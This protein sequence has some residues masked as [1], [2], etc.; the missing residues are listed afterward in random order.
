MYISYDIFISYWW[1]PTNYISLC[2]WLERRQTWIKENQT[3]YKYRTK[4]MLRNWERFSVCQWL[5]MLCSGWAALLGNVG[6]VMLRSHTFTC[7]AGILLSLSLCLWR[8]LWR[9]GPLWIEISYA[10]NRFCRW[11]EFINI[12][13]WVQSSGNFCKSSGKFLVSSDSSSS[14]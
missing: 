8:I 9:C 1:V 6:H 4:A 10:L 2:E 11:L 13:T 3:S 5:L 7:L 14:S 12:C